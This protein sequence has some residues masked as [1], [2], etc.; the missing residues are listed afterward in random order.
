[1][2]ARNRGWVRLKKGLLSLVVIL[3]GYTTSIFAADDGGGTNSGIGKIADNITESFRSLGK[4]MLAIA[5]L[6]GIGFT[7]AAIF[8]FKQHK[9]NPTQ[10]PLGT[11]VALL[12]V[13]TS[14][15]FIANFINPLGAS[16]FGNNAKVSGFQGEEGVN[17]IGG[18][19]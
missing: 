13:G 8:K 18:N 14:L 19:K 11:P 6:A 9:D 16:L 10:I 17:I 15:V 7:I 3:C 2:Y 12:A 5:F 1:M 4:L